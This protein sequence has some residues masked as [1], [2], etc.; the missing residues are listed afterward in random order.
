MGDVAG[1]RRG[2]GTYVMPPTPPPDID[3]EAWPRSLD[4]I[5]AWEPDTLFLTHFGPYQQPRAHVQALLLHLDTWSG[6]VR[7][8]LR[9]GLSDEQGGAEFVAWAL[10]D[11]RRHMSEEEAQQYE[12]AG[13]LDYSWQGL[14]RYVARHP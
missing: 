13:R 9:S 4:A 1:I 10:R 14:Q 7:E 3:L 6:K 5:L 8:L 2:P 12:R 11:L